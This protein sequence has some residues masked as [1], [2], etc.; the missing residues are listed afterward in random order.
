MTADRAQD[1]MILAP[2][3]VHEGV[4][5]RPVLIALVSPI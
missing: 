3:Q 4:T 5:R 1:R 2:G